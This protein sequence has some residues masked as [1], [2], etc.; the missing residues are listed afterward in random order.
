MNISCQ[1]LTI[2]FGLKKLLREEKND[3][4]H[5]LLSKFLIA[6]IKKKTF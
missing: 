3:W 1:N 4:P 6:E 2:F 5:G